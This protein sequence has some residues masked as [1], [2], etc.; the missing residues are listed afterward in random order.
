MSNVQ[1]SAVQ[2]AT[3][4]LATGQPH[5]HHVIFGTGPVGCWIARALRDMNIAV[6]AV[7]RSG[8]RPDLMPVDVEIVAADVSN[9]TAAIAAAEGAT[10]IYQALNPPY[11]QWHEYFPGLQAAALAAARATG[12]RYVSIDNLYMYDAAKPMTEHSPIAPRSKKGEL[13]ARMAEAVM[14][15][16]ARGDLR[17]T[18]LRSSDY[19]GPGVLGS[20]LGEMVFGNLVAGQK[21]QVG[22]SAVMPHAFAYIEDVGRAA[23]TLGT[24]DD[25]IGKV[26][27]AP[28]APARTQG[29]MVA[30]ACQVLGIKPQMTVISPTM[31]RLVGL[32]VPGAR[33]SVEMM[34]EFTE[35]F[36]VDSNQIRQAFALEPTSVDIGIA[37][38]VNWYQQYTHKP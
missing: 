36:I 17:A 2:L 4:Q 37:R 11:H 33:A 5:E 19:Y 22:G 30:M 35:P 14:A 34:Y 13:R 12:A 28:H 29:E 10:V 8:Q 20:A 23:A 6:R 26:W 38:T 1:P 18:V 31:M 32:F 3:G 9:P 21:A 24:Q 27:I 25:A 15:A 7:N 16:H